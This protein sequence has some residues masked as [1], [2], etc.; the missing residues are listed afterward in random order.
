MLSKQ[1]KLDLRKNKDFFSSC[2]KK[3]FTNFSL[4]YSKKKSEVSK[5]IVI[6]PKKTNKLASQ[7]NKIKRAAYLLIENVFSTNKENNI[8][9]II[10][11]KKQISQKNIKDTL[12]QI[13]ERLIETKA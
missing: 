7:R 3:H 9:L 5:A 1:L 6:V 8:D 4:F 11:I 13:K 12:Y 2:K 10:V